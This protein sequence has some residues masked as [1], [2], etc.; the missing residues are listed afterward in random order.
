M[1][2]VISLGPLLLLASILFQHIASHPVLERSQEDVEGLMRRKNSHFNYLFARDYVEDLL[3]DKRS[4][5]EVSGLQ[6]RQLGDI[7]FSHSYAEYLRSKAKLSTMCS[8]LRQ[9]QHIKKS[10]PAEDSEG[11]NQLLKQYMCPAGHQWMPNL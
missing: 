9:L 10:G 11:V 3:E 7:E 5:S 6:T 2:C 4:V 8:F 1:V